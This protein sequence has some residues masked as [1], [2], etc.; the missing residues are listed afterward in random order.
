LIVILAIPYQGV[1]ASERSSGDRYPGST[2]AGSVN[3]YVPF[4]P[5]VRVTD[6]SSPYGFQVEPAIVIDDGGQSIAVSWKEADT[7]SG[8]GRKVGYSSSTDGGYTYTKNKIL[9][10]L[11]SGDSASDTW[12]I[13]DT[14]GNVYDIWIEWGSSSGE[15]IGVSKSTDFGATWGKG[16]QASD[17]YNN[18]LDDKETAIFD[19]NGNMYIIWD[20][21]LSTNPDIADGRLS[22]SRDYGQ[23][24]EP[25]IKTDTL[26]IPYIASDPSG[27]LYVTS[28][29]DKSSM[30]NFTRSTNGGKT[31][32][33]PKQVATGG[34]FE[35]ITVI[36]SDSKGNLYVAY[37]KGPGSAD[38]E[39]YVTKSADGG[40]TWGN[41]VRVNDV[42]TGMQR[43]PEMTIDSSD[44]VHVAWYDARDGNLN[45]YYSNSTDGGKTFG[46]N[47]RV[48]TQGTP[49]SY[50]RPGDY[51]T[52]RTD[53]KNDVFVVWTDGR[54]SDLD[55][56]FARMNATSTPGNKPPNVPAVTG[57]AS[58]FVNVSYAYNVSATDPDSDQVKYTVDWGDGKNDTTA[59]GASGWSAKVS[60]SWT[61]AGT[62]P[63]KARTTDAKGA[64]SAWSSPLSV[65]ISKQYVNHPP[66]AP[67]VTGPTSGKVGV[68]QTY[69]IVGSDPDNDQVKYTVDWGDGNSD[70]TP[71]GPSGWK[72]SPSHAWSAAGTYTVK[73]KTID[74]KGLESG[75][76][77]PLSVSITQGT[78]S[79]PAAPTINGPASGLVNLEFSYTF[80]STD[81]DNDQV[82]FV[83]DWGD[84]NGDTTGLVAS[85]AQ[86][87]AKHTWT[88]VDNFTLKA[89]A[90]DATGLESTW[91]SV[92]ARI[93]AKDD[94]PPVIEHTPVI[95]SLEG[96]AIA[97]K[98]KITDDVGV[99][100]ATLYYRQKGAVDWTSLPLQANGIQYSA[101]IPSSDVVKGVIEYYIYGEDTGGNHANSPASGSSSPYKITVKA[102]PGGGG[103]A[104]GLS[105]LTL[106]IVIIIAVV[107]AGIL[108]ALF[109]WRRRKREQPSY[110]PGYYQ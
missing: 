97:I 46:P 38:M 101:T 93:V 35:I 15:G 84:G 17:T 64:Q 79:P 40:S 54:G 99:K 52:M 47:A 21:I 107:V 9:P 58:G 1:S 71:I 33:A 28:I 61:G 14:S 53:A 57:P 83:I 70:T 87:T 56:Y 60:H 31:W 3:G 75:W 26:W 43:M 20:N 42:T 34:V 6:G 11:A 78:G 106:L 77:S 67:A 76:S 45:I 24:F 19:K 73:A 37:A 95:E 69:D 10:T 51:L 94:K 13:K 90:K 105:D 91:S 32:T 81:P 98:A 30:V 82:Q 4:Q 36:A 100:G 50:T 7:H 16:V 23:T 62:Y 27:N 88:T 108:I 5:N 22:I 89:K 92:V 18:Y 65:V 72:S 68:P 49:T 41:P 96:N 29:D 103:G 48:S 104:L 85:G 110:P 80:T 74:A 55:I 2:G 59:L 86:A 66:N 102:K 12:M 109:A 63:V 44:V 39:V 25:T 8:A